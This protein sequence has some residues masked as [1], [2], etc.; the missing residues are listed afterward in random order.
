VTAMESKT[1]TVS[2]TVGT[3]ADPA[4]VAV[5]DVTPVSETVGAVPAPATV[6]D[7]LTVVVCASGDKSTASFD[8]G[9]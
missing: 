3:D 1:V 2:E 9:V 5:S 6:T 8:G 4:T 7:S